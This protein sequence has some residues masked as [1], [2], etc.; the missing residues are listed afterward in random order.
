MGKDKAKASRKELKGIIDQNDAVALRKVLVAF[1]LSKINPFALGFHSKS[2]HQLM[3]TLLEYTSAS[4]ACGKVS[5]EICQIVLEYCAMGVNA[6]R[7]IELFLISTGRD[8]RENSSRIPEKLWFNVV[9]NVYHD[10]VA[11]EISCLN[12][13]QFFKFCKG[14]LLDES[15]QKLHFSYSVPLM[16]YIYEHKLIPRAMLFSYMR[17]CLREPELTF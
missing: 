3:A 16:R 8:G 17:I 6:F 7:L 10:A 13:E 11:T 14:I 12:R 4:K 15:I 2:G 9:F 5:D 1:D